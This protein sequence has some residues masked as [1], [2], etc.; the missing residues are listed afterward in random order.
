MDRWVVEHT[1][2]WLEQNAM[3]FSRTIGRCAINLSGSSLGDS[4]IQDAILQRLKASTIPASTLKFE[5]TETSAIANLSDARDFI[6]A[7]KA[8]GCHFSLD[9]FGSGLSSFAYLKNLPVDTLKIDG[10]FIREI[11]ENKLD[12][13]MVKSIN[14]IGHVMGMQT[15]AEFVENDEIVELLRE[16][17]I[18]YGQGYG[19]GRP[20]PLA[21]LLL[22]Q[23]QLRA[24]E[25]S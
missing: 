7:L 3:V 9:D 4:T 8:F 2:D 11:V 10:I 23:Q 16:I 17:G 19:L 1:L 13:A 25:V 12:L 15:V 20:K 21:E 14:E 18:D 22:E 5:I 24:L 6:N